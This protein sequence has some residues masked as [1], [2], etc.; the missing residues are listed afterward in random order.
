MTDAHQKAEEA[1]HE[2]CEDAYGLACLPSVELG[3]DEVGCISDEGAQTAQRGCVAEGYEQLGGGY[4][5]ALSPY[6]DNADK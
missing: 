4:V 5:Q 2:G 3:N 1:W 6:L